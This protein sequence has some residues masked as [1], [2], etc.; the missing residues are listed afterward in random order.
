MCETVN[1]TLHII[2]I[3]FAKDVAE[4]LTTIPNMGGNSVN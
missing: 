1:I 4:G 2:N 3:Q